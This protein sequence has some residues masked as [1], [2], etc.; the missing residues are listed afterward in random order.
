VLSKFAAS[1]ELRL[2]VR[3]ELGGDGPISQRKIKETMVALRKM[4]LD[5]DVVTR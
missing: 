4:G 1:K 5:G 2:T 3:F